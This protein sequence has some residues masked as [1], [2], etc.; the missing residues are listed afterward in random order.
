MRGLEGDLDTQRLYLAEMAPAHARLLEL[1]PDA[2]S[3]PARERLATAWVERSFGAFYERPLLLL[4][5]LREDALA[6][7]SKHPLWDAIGADDPDPAS[8]SADSVAAA[9]DR[10]RVWLSLATRHIQT[11]ESSRAV[12]W[13]WPAALI[14]D[15]LP[16]RPVELFDI[17]ASAGLN[18]VADRLEP[19]WTD[20]HERPLATSPLP[21][22]AA[23]A[24][25]DL[26]PLDVLDPDGERWL[27]ACVWP[28]QHDRLERLDQSIAAFRDYAAECGPLSIHD[29]AAH[30][31]PAE[32]PRNPDRFVFAYQ[33]VVRD[34]LP[35][36]ERASFEAGMLEWLAGAPR[37][38]AAWIQL[39]LEA[40]AE[41]AKPF[42]LS[43]RLAGAQDQAL[44]LARTDPHPRTLIVDSDQVARFVSALA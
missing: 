40:G 27:R 14:R 8:L 28:G 16:D 39:E 35:D 20:Q 15:A 21:E 23:R 1:L 7:G 13:L 30:E 37:G 25:F 41:V 12:A 6:S 26:R 32:L 31:I 22:I 3:G 4:A 2:L 29:L 18:L 9:L 17:G 19:I 33:T 44:M 38:G 11:N 43:A 5:A 36:D 42:G 34:Y 24:G 10:E